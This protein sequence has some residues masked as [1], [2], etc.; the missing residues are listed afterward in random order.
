MNSATL[1][2]I[3]QRLQNESQ[4]TL[5]LVLNYVEQITHEKAGNFENF[6]L[7]LSDQQNLLEIKNRPLTQHIDFETFINE[8][9]SKYGF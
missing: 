9:R 1:E 5:D 3:N 4:E 2:L 8:M 7:T 6:K